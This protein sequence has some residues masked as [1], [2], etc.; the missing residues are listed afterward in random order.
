MLNR[1]QSPSPIIS[2]PETPGRP[3]EHGVKGRKDTEME[4]KETPALCVPSEVWAGSET[5]VPGA[6]WASAAPDRQSQAT[7]APAMVPLELVS[8]GAFAHPEGRVRGRGLAWGSVACVLQ[9]KGK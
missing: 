8:W 2:A 6:P 9:M 7:P 4:F 3:S 5:W 1:S